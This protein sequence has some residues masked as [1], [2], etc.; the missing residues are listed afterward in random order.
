MKSHVRFLFPNFLNSLTLLGLGLIKINTMLA[1]FNNPRSSLILRNQFLFCWRHNFDKS[2]Y[3]LRRPQNFA[4][5]PP[6]IWLAVHRTNNW[7]RFCKILRPS[8]N[9]WT[10]TWISIIFTTKQYASKV[11]IVVKRSVKCVDYESITKE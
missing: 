4:K 9:I 11:G 1:N 8:Q 6:V 10:L 2:S 7:W 5:S 3:I